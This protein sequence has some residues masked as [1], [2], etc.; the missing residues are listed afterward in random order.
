[1]TWS[2]DLN[3]DIYNTYKE[4]I[5]PNQKGYMKRKKELWDKTHS[6]YNHLTEKHI[7]EQAL[8]VINK[9]LIKEM[10]LITNET[11]QTTRAD[12]EE[13]IDQPVEINEDNIERNGS[14][15]V[16]ADSTVEG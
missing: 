7:R 8:Q 11:E 13:N 12:N 1:M 6:K 16:S 10:G 9:K 2:Y 15:D 3:R 14:Q 4:A 5:E